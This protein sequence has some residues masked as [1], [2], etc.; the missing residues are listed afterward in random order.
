[1]IVSLSSKFTFHLQHYV[2]QSFFGAI[3]GNAEV[4]A[5]LFEQTNNLEVAKILIRAGAKVNALNWSNDTPLHEAAAEGNTDIVRLLLQKGA[6]VS[7]RT[8][9]LGYDGL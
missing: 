6:K 8:K 4:S 9:N 5:I 7:P 1:M 2:K 3:F